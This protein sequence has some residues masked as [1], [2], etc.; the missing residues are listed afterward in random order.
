[1]K[2]AHYAPFL[3]IYIDVSCCIFNTKISFD[4]PYLLYNIM[5]NKSMMNKL[6]YRI[7]T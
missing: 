1:M 2:K 4:S 5:L 6:Y 7:K 3:S